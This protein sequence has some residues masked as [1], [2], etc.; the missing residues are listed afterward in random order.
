[1]TP[2]YFL[3]IVLAC[4]GATAL[5]LLIYVMLKGHNG[6]I[7]L[8]LTVVAVRV[9]AGLGLGL[10]A[11]FIALGVQ[12]V[13]RIPRNPRSLILI[14]VNVGSITIIGTVIYNLLQ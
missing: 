6:D 5:S 2:K 14:V 9:F 4:I 8:A 13:R 1:M 7:E 10:G 11:G 3:A 12:L